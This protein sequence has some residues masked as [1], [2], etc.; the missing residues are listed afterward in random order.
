MVNVAIL[1]KQ[2][3]MISKQ[4]AMLT[5]NKDIFVRKYNQ[6]AYDNKVVALLEK[7]PDPVADMMN[8]AAKHSDGTGDPLDLEETDEESP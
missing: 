8:D 6:K 7:L 5:A 3:D 2:N 1:E 4:L